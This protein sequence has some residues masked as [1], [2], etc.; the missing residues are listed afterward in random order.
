M[1]NA[2]WKTAQFL[3]TEFGKYLVAEAFDSDES[4]TAYYGQPWA[5]QPVG[6]FKVE[7]H[8]FKRINIVAWD[9]MPPPYR[10]QANAV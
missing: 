10:G 3:P 4:I 7:N 8:R 5:H 2:D 9:S 6:W 1:A